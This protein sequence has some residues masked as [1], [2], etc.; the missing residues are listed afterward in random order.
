MLDLAQEFGFKIAAFHHGVEAYK[1]ADRLAAEG[2]CGALWADW[3]GFKMEAYDGIQ[4]NI[5]LVDCPQGGCAIVHSDSEE[6]IQRLNQEAAKAMTRGAPR[7]PRHPAR[8]RDPLGD[9]ESRE[10]ARHPRPRPARSRPARWPTSWSGT[11]RR[12]ACTRSRTTCSWTACSCT[13][14]ATRRRSRDRTSSCEESCRSSPPALLLAPALAGAADVLIRGA[15]VHTAGAAGTLENADVLVQDGRIAAVGSSL[16]APAGATVVEAHG[17][18]VT[19]GLF[20]G[21][22]Q[23]G[24]E[25]VNLEAS[26]YDAE[27][28]LTAPAWQHMWRPEFDVTPAFNARS[29]VLPVMRV[30]GVTWSML[31][32]LAADSLVIG[33]GSAVSLDGRYDAALEGSRSLF[34]NWGSA[35]TRRF[36]RQPRGAVHAVRPGD[37]RSARARHVRSCSA[38]AA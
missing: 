19:P 2:V 30:E 6:G 36:R 28:K 32:P 38:A 27:L 26:T 16:A 24:L 5:A 34:V 3:W 14:G 9:G 35:A 31:S 13:T 11:A 4:E 1:L 12:S 20:G 10:G 33:Q 29:I 18:P 17:R 25:E 23:V 22:A 21:V 15:R 8:A 37:P 7:R